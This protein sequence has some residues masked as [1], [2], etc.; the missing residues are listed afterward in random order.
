MTFSN[1]YI[2]YN[3]NLDYDNYNDYYDDN[4]GGHAFLDK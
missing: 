1:E 2:A 4:Y 3:H